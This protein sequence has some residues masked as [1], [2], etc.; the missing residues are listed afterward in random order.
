M[1]LGTKCPS[2][3]S[4]VGGSCWWHRAGSLALLAG[5][6]ALRWALAA[7]GSCQTPG[8]SSW[9]MHAGFVKYPPPHLPPIQVF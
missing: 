5:P 8:I 1:G 7:A 2:P 6:G 9:C 3:V 4:P